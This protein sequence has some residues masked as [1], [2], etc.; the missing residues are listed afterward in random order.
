M[1]LRTF[2]LLLGTHFQV[3]K[4]SPT[5]RWY[6]SCNIDEQRIRFLLVI[7]MTVAFA[8]LL[9]HYEEPVARSVNRH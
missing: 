6:L 3:P 7:S 5:T 8:D 9:I 2:R 1:A 4:S